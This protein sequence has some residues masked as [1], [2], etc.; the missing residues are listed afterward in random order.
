MGSVCVAE[1]LLLQLRDLEVDVK[2]QERL[3]S[4]AQQDLVAFALDMGQLVRSVACV[5]TIL[6]Q[7]RF[8]RSVIWKRHKRILR[9]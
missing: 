4:Q 6:M 2:N 3:L 5:D 7:E 9:I 1:I 8:A